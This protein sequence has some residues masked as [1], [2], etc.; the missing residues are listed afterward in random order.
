MSEYGKFNV[1]KEKVISIGKKNLKLKDRGRIS[2]KIQ[3]KESIY[4][5]RI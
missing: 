2:L 4:E 3:K 5:L 1:E